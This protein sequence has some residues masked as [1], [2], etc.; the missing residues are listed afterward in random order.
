MEEHLSV[1]H[2]EVG[3]AIMCSDDP[4]DT[5]ERTEDHN[6]PVF[7]VGFNYLQV[8]LSRAHTLPRTHD[9]FTPSL[10][11][12]TCLQKDLTLRKSNTFAN[13]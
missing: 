12:R 13:I 8:T 1:N 7:E 4:L 10:C 2:E 6:T 5:A 9:M 3:N 11:K